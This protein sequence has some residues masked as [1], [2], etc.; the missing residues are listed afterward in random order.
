MMKRKDLKYNGNETEELKDLAPQLAGVKKVNPFVVHEKY[1]DNLPVIILIKINERKQKPYFVKALGEILR[2][3]FAYPVLASVILILVAVF[4]FNK[5]A[6]ILNQTLS[7]YSFEDVLTE[8]PEIIEGMDESV[9][10]EVLF[11]DN[12]DLTDDFFDFGN[13]AILSSDDLNDYLSEED[14][15]PELFTDF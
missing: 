3:K 6:S 15:T 8:S 11:A 9:L 13:S 5:P 4:V 14:L 2:P 1:F 12:D 7:E 10:I